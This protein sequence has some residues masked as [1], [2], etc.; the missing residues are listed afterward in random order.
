[1]NID[2]N[3]IDEQGRKTVGLASVIF[4]VL[5]SLLALTR[6]AVGLALFHSS[7]LA[8][9]AYAYFQP[10]RPSVVFGLVAAGVGLGLTTFA[11]Q[12]QPFFLCQTTVLVLMGFLPSLF[13]GA[14]QR[15]AMERA[16]ILEH[17]RK[18]LDALLKGGGN[19]TLKEKLAIASGIAAA[20]DHAHDKGIVH[21]D[22]KPGNV[23]ITEDRRPKL[24]D[25]GIAKREDASLTQTGT[26]LGT[27]SYASPEQ[28]KEGKATGL[29]DVFSFGVVIFELLSGQL[30]FPGTSINTILYRI[31]NEPPAEIKPPVTGL[32]PDAW[33]KVFQKVLAKSPKDRYPSCSAFVKDLI[34]GASDLDKD[35]R[36]ELLGQL[37]DLHHNEDPRAELWSKV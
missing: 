32:L 2:F 8:V 10:M 15:K 7:V 23:M 30:P 9:A 16:I 14:E 28:I 1:M 25:F 3:R 11:P 13:S 33:Q 17:N 4:L 20:L 27:P 22:V 18:T 12:G 37:R 36:T 31:V 24:M 6:G 35:S 5:V 19:L 34:E 26:F 29:S 21:R